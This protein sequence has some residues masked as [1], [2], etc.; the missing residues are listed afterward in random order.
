MKDKEQ[1]LQLVHT[2]VPEFLKYVPGEISSIIHALIHTLQSGTLL[3]EPPEFTLRAKRMDHKVEFYLVTH[4]KLSIGRKTKTLPP[5]YVGLQFF[6][7]IDDADNAPLYQPFADGRAID[8]AADFGWE[9][10]DKART[11]A[12]CV[13]G[14]TACDTLETHCYQ[15]IGLQL[16]GGEASMDLLQ[17][18]HS[19]AIITYHNADSLYPY[20][21]LV[22]DPD[23]NLVISATLEDTFDKPTPAGNSPSADLDVED[24]AS[25]AIDE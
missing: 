14:S 3:P 22:F 8:S 6:R 24:L 23:V 20:A 7:R 5:V 18:A 25:E 21:Q 9:V 1:I 4:P 19:G 13:V 15:C 2:E 12:A 16:T 11:E 10:D 17:G